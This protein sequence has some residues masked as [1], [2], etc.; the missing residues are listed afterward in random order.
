M[1]LCR[2]VCWGNGVGS[3]VPT[4]L[5]VTPE[6]LPGQI[7]VFRVCSTSIGCVTNAVIVQDAFITSASVQRWCACFPHALRTS[8]HQ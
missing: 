3:T 7:V 5:K 4:S 8:D 2:G 1:G 6:I